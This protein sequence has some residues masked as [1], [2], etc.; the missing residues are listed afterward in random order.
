MQEAAERDVEA[1]AEE[2]GWKVE[3]LPVE[4]GCRGFGASSTT[5]LLREVEVRGQAHRKATKA[6]ANA[7]E[8]SSHWL[9]L[10]RRDLA[11]APK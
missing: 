6:F 7:A 4:L 1:E 8:K 3:V 5:R 10:K 9:W 2:Q 11:W